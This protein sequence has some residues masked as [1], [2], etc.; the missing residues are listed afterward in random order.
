MP[1]LT[2][3]SQSVSLAQL[4]TVLRQGVRVQLGPQ[5]LQQVAASR[6][7][8]ARIV[9]QAGAV[10][11]V[12]T[13]FGL[14]AQTRIAR[15]RLVELQRNL[16]LSHAAGTGPML[17]DA[18]VR[19]VLVLKLI[20]L[21]RGFSGVRH[22]VLQALTTLVNNDALP[23]IPSRGS[24]GASG[25]LAP[26]AHMTAALLGEGHIRLQGQTL[27]AA[28]ALAQL[29]MAPLTLAPKEGLALLNGTQ[30]ST[31]LAL[32]GLFAAEQVFAAAIVA[33]AMSVDALKGSDAPFDARIHAAR[34]QPGQMHVA[35]LYRELLAGSGIRESHR[36]CDK[37]Q[38]PYSLRCQPQVM[39]ACLDSIAHVSRVLETE[40]NAAT[41]NPL[42]FAADEAVVSGGNFHAEPVAFAADC[43]AVAVAEIGAISERRTAVMVDPKMS[44]LPAFLVPDSGLN[45]GFMIAQ[46]TAAALVSENKSLAHPASVDSIPTCANQE[47]HVSMATYAARRLTDMT[48]N[49]ATVVGIE[50]LCAGQ[51]IEFHRP[52]TSSPPLE[53]AL[54]LLRRKVANYD[55]DRLIHP[56]IEAATALIEAGELATL[57]SL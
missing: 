14:L 16:V 46:V 38:D 24:V 20:S 15:E 28:Q 12:N 51:G 45:S 50:L 18:V 5:A 23:C 8:I 35:G 33:G 55:H 47:D 44:N 11:G 10:Y 30:V 19:L 37:V 43:L 2:L 26:L 54:A 25:D 41:D 39:G 56:D 32:K 7:L 29:G 3:N 22:E 21:A 52:L 1:D 13:G 4:R 53:H 48:R 49:A 34:G 31:A 36:D 40:A 6:D 42:V 17:D 9:N 57:V 27:P